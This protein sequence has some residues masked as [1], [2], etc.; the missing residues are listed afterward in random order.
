[1]ATSAGRTNVLTNPKIGSTVSHT[2][3]SSS[4][5][6]AYSFTAT[7]ASSGTDEFK[8]TW[9]TGSTVVSSTGSTKVTFTMRENPLNV[10]SSNSAKNQQDPEGIAVNLTPAGDAQTIGTLVAVLFETPATNTGDVTF[11]AD[12]SVSLGYGGSYSADYIGDFKFKGGDAKSRSVLIV[13]Q[14]PIGGSGI[15]DQCLF[16]I[17][18][19]AGNN[20]TITVLGK[21]TS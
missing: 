15:T 7:G 1:M 20:I 21:T 14:A 9:S 17:A 8:L 4:V 13:P 11:Q 10:T 18:G 16:S 5:D 12:G 6:V 2:L 3:T 19:S